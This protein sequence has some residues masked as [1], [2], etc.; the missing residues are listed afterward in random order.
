MELTEIFDVSQD[1]R[2]EER[3]L[4]GEVFFHDASDGLR[5]GSS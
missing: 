5:G 3:L 1:T 2:M 4:G